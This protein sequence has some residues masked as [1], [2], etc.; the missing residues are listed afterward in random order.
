M[1]TSPELP[2]DLRWLRWAGLAEGTS[3]LVLF[4][5]AMPLKYFAGL[6]LAV[7]IVGS[8]HGVLFLGYLALVLV[9]LVRHRWPVGRGLLLGVAAII[10]FGPFVID[11]RIPRWHTT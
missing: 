4:F 8:L 6:P 10:P 2:G 5:V 9:I 11:R 1:T 3:T 7:T